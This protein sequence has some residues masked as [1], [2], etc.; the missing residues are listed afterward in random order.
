MPAVAA[1]TRHEGLDDSVGE[2]YRI[3]LRLLCWRHLHYSRVSRELDVISLVVGTPPASA[4]ASR[5]V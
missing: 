2:R 4:G 1:V 5:S 3:G